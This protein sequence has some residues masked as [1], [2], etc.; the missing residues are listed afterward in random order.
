MCRI[1]LLVQSQTSMLQPSKFVTGYEITSHVLTKHVAAYSCWGPVD[2]VQFF[3]HYF[4]GPKV[5]ERSKSG[6]CGE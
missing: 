2:I 5:I 6:K 3:Q 4:H 1:E